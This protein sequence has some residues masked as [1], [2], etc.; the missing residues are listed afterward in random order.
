[1]ARRREPS[2]GPVSENLIVLAMVVGILLPP[3]GLILGG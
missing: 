1:V 3:V 2:S